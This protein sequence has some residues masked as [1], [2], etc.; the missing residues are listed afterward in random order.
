[1]ENTLISGNYNIL[2]SI[3]IYGNNELMNIDNSK[4]LQEV[5]E[6][7][8][9]TADILEQVVQIEYIRAETDRNNSE[10]NLNYSKAIAD[11]GYVIRK[12]LDQ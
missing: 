3:V 9:R 12:L 10:A 8:K 6:L 2:N 7:Q 5:I 11:Y 4:I 1:M